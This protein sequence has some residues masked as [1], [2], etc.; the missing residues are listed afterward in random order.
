MDALQ[1]G[2]DGR[3]KLDTGRCIG[4]G[5]CVST[6]GAESLVLV[7]KCGPEQRNV[8][9]TFIKTYIGMARER[10]KLKPAKLAR[11]WIRTKIK[12]KPSPKP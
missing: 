3:V 5:L 9:E 8:P 2:V 10:G 12:A 11:A 6:C 4:C 1:R 7:R